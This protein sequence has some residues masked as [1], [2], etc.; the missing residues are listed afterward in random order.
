MKIKY[1]LELFELYAPSFLQES[2]DNSGLL[3][4]NPGSGIKSGL[5]CLDITEEIIDEAITN[6]DD[7]II[8]HHPL[9]FEGLKRITGKNSIERII[10]KAVK[11][12]IAILSLHTN[13]DNV[14]RGVNGINAEKMGLLNIEILKPKEGLLKKLVAFCPKDNVEE[15]REAIFNAGAGNIGNYDKCSFNIQ[16]T[17]SFRGD[18]S[19][20]PYVGKKGSIHY[21]EE[22]RIE[23]IYPVY[24]EK[25]I[26][27]ALFQSH[28]YEEV[29]YDLY[30]LTNEFNQAGAGI[31]GELP[32]TISEKKF[33]DLLKDTFNLKVIKHSKLLN[34]DIRKVAYCG[35]SGS[36][37]INDAIRNGADVFVSGD[38]K[39]HQFFEAEDKILIAD[40]GHYES[41]QYTKELIFRII[42][43]KFPIFALRISE[44]ITNAIDYYI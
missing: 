10:L 24:K 44:S 28:P 41:E 17:G 15:V 21:E 30:K 26:L 29:A 8:S 14:L 11:N 23:T 34:K 38:I 7:I 42:N 18:D 9:I 16:G 13:L 12:D 31:T 6:K 37:L 32:D 19:T 33:L 43:K 40:I 36:F 35:G 25:N 20:N 27:D 39:Y 3:L 2:Y 5:V 1:L 4:G 22:V